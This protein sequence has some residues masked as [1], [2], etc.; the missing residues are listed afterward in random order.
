MRTCVTTVTA[1]AAVGALWS[2]AAHAERH[3]GWDFGG[4]L[5]YQDAQHIDFDGG[6]SAALDDDLGLALTF[7]YRFNERLEL[8]F[9]LDWNNVDYTVNVANGLGGTGFRADGDLEAFTPW[10]GLN[11]NL[12]KGDFT[13]YVS[14]MVGWAFIDTNIPD[15]PPV[16][17]CWWDPWWGYVCGTWQ[18]TR[19]IDELAYGLGA[20]VRWDAS[21][22]LSLR[23]GYEKRWLDL[24]EA[25]STPG[26]DQLKLS[27]I[28][29]Y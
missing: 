11:V 17:S 18:D 2:A 3:P 1:L 28:A 8:T 21:S 22:T 27:V 25:T 5:I 24:G 13:P 6:S 14:G 4:A 12:M 15:G 16:N 20:G 7:G 10:V 9:G 23:F 19:S 26:F 29:R